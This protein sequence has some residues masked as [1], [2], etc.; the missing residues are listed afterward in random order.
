MQPH[1]GRRNQLKKATR[2]LFW[3]LATAFVVV[4]FAQL[5][6]LVANLRTRRKAESLLTS[7]R[8]LRIGES[9]LD[10]LQP[11]L[12][13]YRASTIP[14]SSNC[15]AADVAYGILVTNETMDTLGLNHP[16]LLRV[17]VK[18]VSAT[19]ALSFVS[20]RLCEFRYSTASLLAG[21]HYPSGNSSLTSAPILELD[22]QTAV[23][24]ATSQ[25]AKAENYAISYSQARL[26]GVRESGVNLTLRVNVTLSATQAEFQHA[27]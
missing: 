18:P 24:A 6:V 11:V 3:L 20:G 12:R 25:G 5:A 17:G 27:L 9:R 23:Q 7:L 16:L 19:A 10:D 1:T 22:A 8:I 21:S 13:T 26:Q 4:L 2:G 14:V 15:P